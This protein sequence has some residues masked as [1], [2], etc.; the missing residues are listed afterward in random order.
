M[1]KPL[2]RDEAYRRLDDDLKGMSHLFGAARALDVF[3]EATFLPATK[4]ETTTG[5]RSPDGSVAIYFEAAAVIAVLVLLKQMLELQAQEQTSN[6]IKALLGLAPKTGRRRSKCRRRPIGAASRMRYPITAII[7]A[8]RKTSDG[9]RSPLCR[10]PRADM[11]EC[12]RK[13]VL[14]LGGQK[15]NR[16]TRSLE[17]AATAIIFGD[18]PAPSPFAASPRR[19]R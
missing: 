9:R 10:G 3:Q 2:V 11:G 8:G 17:D 15:L 7:G 16:R 4:D 1:L 12:S 6:A 13:A 18:Q 5:A 14:P 19:D